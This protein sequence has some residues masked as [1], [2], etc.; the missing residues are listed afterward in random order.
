MLVIYVKTSVRDAIQK[1]FDKLNNDK[2]SSKAINAASDEAADILSSIER[3][4]EGIQLVYRK[5]NA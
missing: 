3:L 4:N 2:F 5:L 1:L